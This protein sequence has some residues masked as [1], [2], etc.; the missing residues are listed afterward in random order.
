[1]LKWF[2]IRG[3]WTEIKRIRWSSPKELA[4][5]STTVLVFTASF[6]LYFALCTAVIAALLKFLGVL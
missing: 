6:A 2:S 3:I 1:M 5:D 4:K